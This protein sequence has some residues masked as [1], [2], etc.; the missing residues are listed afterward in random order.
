MDMSSEAYR[1]AIS[2]DQLSSEDVRGQERATQNDLKSEQHGTKV[3]TLWTTMSDSWSLNVCPVS[4]LDCPG[5]GQNIEFSIVGGGSGGQDGEQE[6]SNG[7]NTPG[8]GGI[9]GSTGGAARFNFIIPSDGLLTSFSGKIGFPGLRTN[10]GSVPNGATGSS[11]KAFYDGNMYT[12]AVA[13]GASFLPINNS[14]GIDYVSFGGNAVVGVQNSVGSIAPPIL[15]NSI[16]N[17]IF[18]G[19]PG[20]VGVLHV[21]NSSF[22]SLGGVCNGGTGGSGSMGWATIAGVFGAGGAGGHGGYNNS[23]PGCMGHGSNYG[24]TQG[25]SGLS[26]VVIVSW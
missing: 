9:G 4:T 7:F 14:W 8:S 23:F 2:M 26:G 13:N 10:H 17:P 11:V 3:F 25:V 24:L 20:G 22:P 15:N 19:P 21:L 12:L 18:S 1:Q 6:G 16:S 5:Y